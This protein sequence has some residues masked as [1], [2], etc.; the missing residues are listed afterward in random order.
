MH[1]QAGEI[2]QIADLFSI[3]SNNVGVVFIDEAKGAIILTK[4]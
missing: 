1:G 2:S 4:E 3:S